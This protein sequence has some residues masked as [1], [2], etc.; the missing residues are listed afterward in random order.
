MAMGERERTIRQAHKI[1]NKPR[2]AG[3]GSERKCHERYAMGEIDE[4][5]LEEC[6]RKARGQ[7]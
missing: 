2:V 6:I 5:G 7:A 1:V 4:A 3:L